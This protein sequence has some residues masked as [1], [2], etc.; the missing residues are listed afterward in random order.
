MEQEGGFP[1]KYRY[2]LEYLKPPGR[3]DQP[4]DQR[5]IGILAKLYR[6]WAALRMDVVRRWHRARRDQGNEWSWGIGQGT[7]AE[8]AAW[9][10]A[11][12]AEVAVRERRHHAELLVDCVKCYEMVPLRDLPGAA[13][14]QGFPGR[15]AAVAIRQYGGPRVVDIGGSLPP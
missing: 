1:A 10:T 13:S 7:G 5:P 6:G 3:G 14:R 2:V 15:I 12:R 11:F 9:T 4:L 8:D